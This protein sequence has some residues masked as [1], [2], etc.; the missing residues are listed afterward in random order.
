MPEP[1]DYF[2]P[3]RPLPAKRLDDAEASDVAPE[4]FDCVLTQTPD[5]AAAQAILVE[6]QRRSIPAYRCTS[7]REHV[8]EL[9]VRPKDH[10]PA[11]QIASLIFARRAKLKS[12]PRPEMNPPNLRPGVSDF[13]F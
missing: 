7:G 4:G 11:A 9:R 13:L 3:N 5:H 12:Y 6:L 10:I 1:L 8:T 2:N